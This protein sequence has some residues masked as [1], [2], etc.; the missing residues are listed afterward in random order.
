MIY[1]KK[2][3]TFHVKRLGFSSF[4]IQFTPKNT[5]MA[6]VEPNG[7]NLSIRPSKKQRFPLLEQSEKFEKKYQKISII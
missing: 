6:T 2:N 1:V 3:K 4:F 7:P 5:P